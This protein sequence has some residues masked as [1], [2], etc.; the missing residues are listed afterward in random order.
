MRGA[1]LSPFIGLLTLFRP[2]QTVTFGESGD[3][4][5]SSTPSSLELVVTARSTFPKV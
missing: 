1:L 4:L 2:M 3:N 5:F